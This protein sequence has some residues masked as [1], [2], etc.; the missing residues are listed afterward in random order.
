MSVSGDIHHNSAQNRSQ[1]ARKSWLPRRLGNSYDDVRRLSICERGVVELSG[2]SSRGMACVLRWEMHG[3]AGKQLRVSVSTSVRWV[4]CRLF[5]SYEITR[6]RS[7]GLS[8]WLCVNVVTQP[9]LGVEPDRGHLY[10]QGDSLAFGNSIDMNSS[11]RR[12]RAIVSALRARGLG[13]RR[14]RTAGYPA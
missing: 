11:G 6:G 1:A 5:L 8:M 12:H 13:C 3:I 14:A 4:S 7:R 2:C 10:P 9:S